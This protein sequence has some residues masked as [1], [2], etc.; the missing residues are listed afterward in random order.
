MSF[1]EQF[2]QYIETFTNLSSREITK[3]IGEQ[4]PLSPMRVAGQRILHEREQAA[5]SRRAYIAIVISIFSLIVSFLSYLN[6]SSSKG[7]APEKPTP[8]QKSK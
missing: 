4:T 2:A 1:D 7:L 8:A 5:V 6:A 3:A